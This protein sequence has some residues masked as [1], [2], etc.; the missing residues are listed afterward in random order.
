MNLKAIRIK[1][2][3]SQY[4]LEKISGVRQ[5]NISAYEAGTKKPKTDTVIKLA[6]A[7]KVSTDELLGVK[8]KRKKTG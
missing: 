1:Q 7:L 8:P 2:G 4:R 3:L 5:G 6:V